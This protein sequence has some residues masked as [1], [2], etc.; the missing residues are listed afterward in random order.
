MLAILENKNNYA[1]S[2]WRLAE[3]GRKRGARKGGG[4]GG[5]ADTGFAGGN[6][7]VVATYFTGTS[8]LASHAGEHNSSGVTR[9]LSSPLP[10][11]RSSALRADGGNGRKSPCP[12][13]WYC[14]TVHS[15]WAAVSRLRQRRRSIYGKWLLPRRYRIIYIRDGAHRLAA[16]AALKSALDS[17]KFVP[18]VVAN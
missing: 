11:T 2:R 13:L 14:A 12:Y 10:A 6:V 15:D 1:I 9:C 18:L 3:R 8:G 7:A 17:F 4:G 16:R 5:K